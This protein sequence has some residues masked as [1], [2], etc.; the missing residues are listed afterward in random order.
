MANLSDYF[1]GAGGFAADFYKPAM[2]QFNGSNTDYRHTS[3]TPSGN[4]VTVVVR[5][6][7]EQF[8]GT[9]S[10]I[11]AISADYGTSAYRFRIA[12]IASGATDTDAR[13]KA[14]AFVSS[15]TDVTVC[16]LVSTVD[17]CDGED[18]VL[19]FAFDGDNGTALLYV[20][21]ADVDNTSW[22]NRVA[23]TTATLDTDA[24]FVA[25]GSFAG[26]TSWY[27][28]EMGYCG[29]GD[30]YRTNPE[31]FCD[32]NGRP[33]PLDETTWTEWGSQPAF[34]NEHGDMRNNVGSTIN[35][36]QNGTITVAPAERP[37]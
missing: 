9:A 34:W 15:S 32:S 5:F 11:L 1:D 28:G 16:N 3:Y 23:P 4:L 2:M 22:T 26:V 36:T 21:G 25:F 8:S 31:D 7:R 29:Y 24:N 18:H 17:V 14:T 6:N 37:A 33:L 12:V 35:M 27:S 30:V 10:E 13:N 20:D 19:F